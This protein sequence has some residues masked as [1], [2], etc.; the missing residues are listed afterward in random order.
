MIFDLFSRRRR[1]L[2]RPFPPEWQQVLD[3]D[4]FLFRRLPEAERERLR[5]AVKLFVAEKEWE[6]CGG[7]AV[8]DAMRVVVAAH[9]GLL[10][11]G[12]DGFRFDHLRTVLLYPASYLVEDDGPVPGHEDGGFA[13]EGEAVRDGIDRRLGESHRQGAIV[14]AWREAL[15]QSRRQGGQ[16]V[17]LHELAHQ[18]AE[19]NEAGT[20]LPP[21]APT[22]STPPTAEPGLAGRWEAVIEAEWRHLKEES[23]RHRPTLLDPYGAESPAELFAVATETFFLHPERMRDER[24]ELYG[25]LAAFY[26]QDPAAWPPATPEDRAAAVRAEERYD[27]HMIAEHTA[28][29]RLQPDYAESYIARALSYQQLGEPALALID[30][31]RYLALQPGDAEGYLERAAV[32]LDLDDPDSAVA[33][34]TRALERLPGYGRA[35]TDRAEAHLARGDHRAAL[36]DLDAALRLDPED[37]RAWHQRGVVRC[38]L[39]KPDK[40][41][42]DLDQAIRLSPREPTYYAWRADAHAAR[43]NQKAALADLATALGLEPEADWLLEQRGQVHLQRGAPADA[44]ADFEQAAALAPEE[45]LHHAGRAAALIDLDRLE[46]AAAAAETA[47]RLDPELPQAHEQRGAA[48]RRLGDLQG[49]VADLTEA[50]R[51]DPESAEAYEERAEAY[52]ALGEKKKAA[53]DRTRA[54]ELDGR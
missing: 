46:E 18:L 36:A 51:L 14:L 25:V 27:R 24:A 26:R 21:I 42:P 48:R 13:V 5:E 23:D 52:R 2:R 32:H 28:A 44:L 31:D 11:L 10:G 1:L 12:L 40:A 29:I 41:L 37:D 54:A 35:Y 49:A 53:A 39:G 47:I 20:G 7:L 16:N 6:G 45:A 19:L 8:T 38:E 9:A 4:V 33:D 43:G 15:W 30:L 50:L 34:C 17:I 3:R 22:A